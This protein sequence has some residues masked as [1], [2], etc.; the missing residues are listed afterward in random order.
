MSYG[1]AAPVGA[2]VARSAKVPDP[3]FRWASLK[4]P[5]YDNNLACVEVTPKG[6]ELWWRR[7]VVDA[8]DQ[9]NPRLEEVAALTVAPRRAEK[10]ARSIDRTTFRRRYTLARERSR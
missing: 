1:L 5:W 6:L 7:G 4:G 8:G 2:S 9:L 10:P 3:P